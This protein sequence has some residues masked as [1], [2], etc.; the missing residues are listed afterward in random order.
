MGIVDA[1]WW[2]EQQRLRFFESPM[3]EDADRDFSWACS[4]C[5]FQNAAG[6]WQCEMCSHH[7]P[8]ESYYCVLVLSKHAAACFVGDSHSLLFFVVDA[9][10]GAMVL[11]MNYSGPTAVQATS[12]VPLQGNGAGDAGAGKRSRVELQR[13]SSRDPPSPQ[14][15]KVRSRRTARQKGTSTG[16]E[17]GCN[18]QQCFQRWRDAPAD[19]C[20]RSCR[21]A[22]HRRQNAADVAVIRRVLDTA[23]DCGCALSAGLVAAGRAEYKGGCLAAGGCTR[24]HEEFRGQC[25]VF[26]LVL[27]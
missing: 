7:K 12:T 1:A 22:D 8:G 17:V 21:K 11:R 24:V 14:H 3:K 25:F 23:V 2:A 16:L 26:L 5:T 19:C 20:P 10:A 9:L 18:F 4:N 15:K 13:Q 6:M 27:C